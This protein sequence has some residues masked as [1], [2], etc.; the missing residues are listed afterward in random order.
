MVVHFL[1]MLCIIVV[2]NWYTSTVCKRECWAVGERERFTLTENC[3]GITVRRTRPE[4]LTGC[5]VK[6]QKPKFGRPSDT[7]M[8]SLHF[9]VSA[10]VL[11]TLSRATTFSAVWAAGG[12]EIAREVREQGENRT[13]RPGCH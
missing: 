12:G 3:S 4:V 2:F 5:V 1:L 6:R 7:L 10:G 9:A 11:A 8:G 13:R